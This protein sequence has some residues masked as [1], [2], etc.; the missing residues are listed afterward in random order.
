M[1]PVALLHMLFGLW[2]LTLSGISTAAPQT[3]KVGA[4]TF[5]PYLEDSTGVI[6]RFLT[7]INQSQDCYRFVLIK[8]PGPQTLYR[9]RKGRFRH[10]A[11]RKSQNGAGI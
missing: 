4:Y 10:D 3:I 6:P 1:K 7:L 8:M 11:V 5:P 2:I 9:T